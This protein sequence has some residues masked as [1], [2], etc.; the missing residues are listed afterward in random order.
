MPGTRRRTP[1]PVRPIPQYH[2][3][4][5]V[6]EMRRLGPEN[7]PPFEDWSVAEPPSPDWPE[8]EP[9]DDVSRPSTK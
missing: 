1:K 3:E 4:D 5:L 8:P 2:I 6:A 9:L 7:E